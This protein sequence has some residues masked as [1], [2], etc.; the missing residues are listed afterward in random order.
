METED[1]NHRAARSREPHDPELPAA[2]VD[3][4]RP[5]RFWRKV[6]VSVAGV[7]L[8]LIGIPMIPL[9]GPG[10]LVVFTGLAV[11]G[12]EFPWAERLRDKIL[13]RFR[14]FMATRGTK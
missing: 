4:V 12:S 14:T 13:T 5:S 3:S 1:I 8:I 7:T 11:L 9:I 10:W 6:G 2:Q